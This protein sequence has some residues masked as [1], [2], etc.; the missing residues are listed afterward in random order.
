M[1]VHMEIHAGHVGPVVACLTT[2]Q[3]VPGSN[4]KLA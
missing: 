4:P 3:Q 2:D 1:Y